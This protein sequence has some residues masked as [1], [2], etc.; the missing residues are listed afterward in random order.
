MTR[1]TTIA[2]AAMLLAVGAAAQTGSTEVVDGD[3]VRQGGVSWRLLSYD[4]P[5]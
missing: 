4:T 3:T 2:L 5:G 1:L